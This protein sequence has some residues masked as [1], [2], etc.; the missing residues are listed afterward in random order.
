MSS[1]SPI[2]YGPEHKDPAWRWGAFLIGLAGFAVILLVWSWGGI[3]LISRWW[4]LSVLTGILLSVRSGRAWA[5][6]VYEEPER[7][8]VV[9][10]TIEVQGQPGSTYVLM[11]AGKPR[12]G[13][14]APRPREFSPFWWGVYTVFVRAPVALGDVILTT[15]WRAVDGFWSTST[16]SLSRQMRMDRVDHPERHAPPD[17]ERF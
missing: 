6:G 15:G 8:R 11:D 7:T 4:W 12:R 10:P 5:R 1:A 13:G 16:A 2:P 9:P 14:R 17:R 3:N